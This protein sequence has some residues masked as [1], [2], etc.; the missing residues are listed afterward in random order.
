MIY[1]RS[2]V[3]LDGTTF[4]LVRDAEGKHL[5]I[6]GDARGFEGKSGAEGL[7]LGPLSRANAA[8]L[9]DRLSW[10]RPVPLGLQKSAGFG[11]RL[12]PATPGHLRATRAAGGIAP[13]VAQQSMRENVRTGRTPQ[14]V[15]DDAM[16]GVFQEGWREPW[17]ADADHLKTTE[18]IDL[19]AAA[20]YTFFTIDPGDH[21]DSEADLSPAGDTEW[22][23]RR[24][25]GLPWR[26]LGGD[27]AQLRARYLGR[28]F[29]VEGFVL[30]LGAEALL[31]A[32]AK[33][34]RAIA[35]TARMYRH[36]V[37]V[38]GSRPFELEVSVDETATPTT[39]EEHLFIA[40]E[41]ARLGVRWVSLAPRY[42]GRFEKGVD[43]IG[44]L[45]EF[46]SQ[47]E[48][49]A[50]IARVLGPYKLSIHSGSDKF[51][52]YPFF[53]RE[54]HELV[55]LKTAGTSYLEALRTIAGVDPALFRQILAFGRD[56]YERD[57]A[58][59]HVSGE[60]S[61]VPA[62]ESL[63]DG[64]LAGFLDLFDAR[65]VLHVTFG[66]ALERFGREILAVL[67]AHEEAYY[68]ALETHFARHLAPFAESAS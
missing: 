2:V 6:R 52:V 40:S 55:H 9:R 47:L 29:G 21:V 26:D 56:C 11:D 46:A 61:R 37:T 45:A 19:C 49:H 58:T 30:E 4:M 43:Y 53:A 22:L 68:A 44:D 28:Q 63:A 36:L 17:G 34:G 64:Q 33:Y 8:A 41:L 10:L 24:L 1:P 50:A 66:S 23:Q 31:R 65:Q 16:W 32:A 51:T 42:V 27:A 20:G 5:S 14:Q 62:P 54:A 35:H 18:D 59:Y 7:F 38:M 13:I 67:A 25:E 48:K 12:G 60:L 39:P 57:R 3:E 15:M